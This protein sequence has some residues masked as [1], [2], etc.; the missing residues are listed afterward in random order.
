MGWKAGQH[1]FLAFPTIGPIESHPFTIAN[2]Y[3]PTEDDTKSKEAE[4]MWIVR[5]R[6]GLTHR[7]KEQVVR[8]KGACDLP[9]FMD[10]PYGAPADITGFDTCVFIAGRSCRNMYTPSLA[11]HRHRWFRRCVH[12]P[13]DARLVDVSTYLFDVYSSIIMNVM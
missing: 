6:G 12:Q 2:M 7:L 9:I 11:D 13:K 10:G 5:V 8:K 3:E 4:I 1:L